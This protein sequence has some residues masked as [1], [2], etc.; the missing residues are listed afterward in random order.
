MS[1]VVQFIV[2]PSRTNS[3][4]THFNRFSLMLL[5]GKVI[6]NKIKKLEEIRRKGELEGIPI[7]KSL[8]IK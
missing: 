7:E 8:D 5:N 3:L 2:T 4:G 6:R 1:F